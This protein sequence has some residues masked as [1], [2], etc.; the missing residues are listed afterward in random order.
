MAIS[1]LDLSQI[2]NRFREQIDARIK[3]ILDEGWYLQGE[4]NEL[5]SKHF[6]DFCGTKFALGVA[7]GLDALNL[8]IKPTVSAPVMRL[9]FP[10][11]PISPLFWPYQKTDVPLFWSNRIST[12]TTSILT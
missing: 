4:Q 2:N 10:Q 1:F 6:A 7:N 8:I 3:H 11:T 12:L 9:L 5:F